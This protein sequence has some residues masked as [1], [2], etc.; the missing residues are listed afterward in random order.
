M[1]WGTNA[2][3]Q[4]SKSNA[5]AYCVGI[6]GLVEFAA[7]SDVFYSANKISTLPWLNVKVPGPPRV[8]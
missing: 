6:K 4:R 2:D 5:S 3:V 8:G 7:Q 1:P